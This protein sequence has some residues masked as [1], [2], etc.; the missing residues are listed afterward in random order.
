MTT[1]Q[2]RLASLLA[3]TANT[4]SANEFFEADEIQEAGYTSTLPSVKVG[5]KTIDV[6]VIAPSKSGDNLQQMLVGPNGEVVICRIRKA[7][8][9]D[10]LVGTNVMDGDFVFKFVEL[11]N[12]SSMLIASTNRNT[13]SLDALAES[14]ASR[15][16]A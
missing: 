2:S 4:S 11:D 12:G 5:K 6:N 3:A 9:D 13:G 1:T 15:L 7:D 16:Q 8:Q 14:I 10:K